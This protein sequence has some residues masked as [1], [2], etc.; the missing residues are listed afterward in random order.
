MSNAYVPRLFD[1]LADSISK[2]LR[3]AGSSQLRLHTPLAEKVLHTKTARR[4][5]GIGSVFSRAVLHTREK[6]ARFH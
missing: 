6:R 3:T 4:C 2:C 5:D 1:E